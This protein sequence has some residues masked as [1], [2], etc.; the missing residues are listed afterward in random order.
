MKRRCTIERND[1]LRDKVHD[2]IQGGRTITQIA[3]ALLLDG[4]SRAAIGRYVRR[5]KSTLRRI[6]AGA[7]G[8]S[9]G[10]AIVL[11]P[12]VQ[13]R[14]RAFH[15]LHSKLGRRDIVLKEA[16]LRA[17]LSQLPAKQ[18]PRGVSRERINFIKSEILGL[19]TDD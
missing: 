9:S 18:R 4:A 17:Y 3:D 6:E 12:D 14:M 2:L 15:A 13:A 5:Y 8:Q 10:P 19:R 7:S 11:A 16:A 1:A